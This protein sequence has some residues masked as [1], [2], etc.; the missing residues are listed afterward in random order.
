MRTT[1]SPLPDD[2]DALKALLLAQEV[3]H[4]QLQV[5]QLAVVHENEQRLAENTRIKTQV[6]LLQ[7]RLNLAIAINGS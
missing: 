4:E 1:R 2:M 6:L 7:E 3:R 5:D